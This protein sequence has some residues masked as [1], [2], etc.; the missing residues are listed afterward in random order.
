MPFLLKKTL[1]YRKFLKYE[2]VFCRNLKTSIVSNTTIKKPIYI[3]LFSCYLMLTEYFI[4]HID[5]YFSYMKDPDDTAIEDRIQIFQFYSTRIIE[6]KE[7]SFCILNLKP[8][9]GVSLQC[10]LTCET[11]WRTCSFSS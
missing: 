8:C 4:K 7:A 5:K 1:I 6:H 3:Y 11:A 10:W 9:F 2:S